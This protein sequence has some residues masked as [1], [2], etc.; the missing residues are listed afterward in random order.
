[1]PDIK[2]EMYNKTVNYVQ[3]DLRRLQSIYAIYVN[4]KEFFN[5]T[6]ID[7]IFQLK[8]YNDDTFACYNGTHWEIILGELNSGLY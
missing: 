6:M 8:S 7:N 4:K 2:D 1:M 5:E 3:G